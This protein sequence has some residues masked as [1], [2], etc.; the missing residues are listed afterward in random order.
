MAN[1]FQFFMVFKADAAPA[2]AAAKDVQDGLAGVATEARKTSGALDGNA[3]A[4]EREAKAARDAAKAAKDRA[5]AEAAARD[6]AFKA[7]GLPTKAPAFNADEVEKLRDQYVPLHAAQRTYARQLDAIAL[8]ERGGALTA[9]ESAAA[10]ARLKAAHDAETAALQRSTSGHQAHGKAM[11]LSA[12]DAKVL[13]YQ[14]NDIV[15]SIALGMPITQVALQQGPQ[16]TQ[17]Y[18]GVGNTMRAI[19]AALTVSR[20]AVAATAATVL[21]GATQWNA[22]L[23]SV[24]EVDTAAAGLGRGMAGTRAEM[25]A[26]AVAGANAAGISVRAARSMEAAFLRTGRIEGDGFAGL[27]G[28]SKDFAATIGIEAEAAGSALAELF[29]DPARGADVLYRQYGL[30]SAATAQ[31]AKDLAAQN[32]QAEAQAVLIQ[33]LP[34]NLAD[35]EAATTALG[36]AWDFVGTAASNA[37]DA[38][39]GAINR[40]FD[41]PSLEEQIAEQRAIVDRMAGPF[42]ARQAVPSAA[43]IATEKAKLADLL[44]EQRSRDE[45]DA[46]D[47]NEAEARRRSVSILQVSEATPANKKAQRIRDLNNEIATLQ[48]ATGEEGFSADQL[49]EN[50]TALEAK[51]RALVA[52]TG[53]TAHQIALDT[54][55]LQLATERN[56]VLRGQLILNQTLLN[57]ADKELSIQEVAAEAMRE[58]NKVVNEAIEGAR[59]QSGE[60]RT[61]IEIRQ[62]LNAQ[63][64]AGAIT[65]DEANRLL[66]EELELHPLV[67]AAASAH[68]DE[69][70]ELNAVIAERREL[71]AA[72][73]AEEKHASSISELQAYSKTKTEQLEQTRVELSL[74]GQTIDVRQR[75]LAIYLEEQELRKLGVDPASVQG[76]Q[77]LASAMQNYDAER[78]L[79]RLTDA[80]GRVDDAASGAIDGMIDG[81]MSG[82]LS[83]ALRSV[84]QEALGLFVELDLK[85]PL[86]N[87]IM[88]SDLPTLNDV[89]GLPGIVG[90]LFGGKGGNVPSNVAVSAMNMPSM[91]VTATMVQLTAA[92]ITGM[93]TGALGMAGGSGAAMAGLPGSGDVQSQVWAFFAGKGLA[94][95]QIAG[96]MGNV[97]AESGFNPLAVGD[98]GRAHGLFQWNDR[99]PSLFGA[100]GGRENLGS[101]EAQLAFAWQELMTSENSSYKRLLASTNVEEATAAFVGFERPSG[102]SVSNPQGSMHWDRRAAAAEAALEKFEGQTIATSQTLGQLGAGFTGLGSTLAQTIQ[103]IGAQHGTKGS[104]IGGLL[105]GLGSAIGI[106]GFRVGGAT[107]GSNPDKVAG[108]VHEAEYVFDAEATRRIGVTNLEALRSGAMR[109]YK[110]GGYVT[111]G[112]PMARQAR[113][114]DAQAQNAPTETRTVFE[115]NVGGTGDAQILAGVKHLMEAAFDEHARLYLPGQVRA[116]MNDKWGA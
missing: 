68:G 29:A 83:D 43:M 110:T 46:R 1:P 71:T 60:L 55:E 8:A 27:I 115:L 96:I 67:A 76:A 94:P 5:A 97:S 54:I 42:A 98:A 52:L 104:L 44:R 11:Q 7:Q 106:P 102:Y 59:A 26:A 101:V 90:R 48:S 39:G 15:Q 80:W 30:I 37:G 69:Q 108:V 84:A 18:G 74:V 89:G 75:L 40:V 2:K 16:I 82:D 58:R 70:K 85:N 116:V 36:R 111:G 103:G 14:I 91:A 64:A 100:I 45:A 32:R 24:K 86:K 21:I 112:R 92:N 49:A 56:P 20:V 65:A 66:R 50:A 28:M 62:R 13:T 81:L 78:E 79:D 77:L 6:A 47:A 34:G 109:G 107:G 73:A 72:L 31:L 35:A 9:G 12:N 114:A 51:R 53:A 23:R 19:G 88:G 63:Q 4:L 95:H 61:E 41:G 105:T 113:A 99:A 25:E 17:I 87:A 10:K 22:Y 33:A 3:A 57:L 38:I 93:P